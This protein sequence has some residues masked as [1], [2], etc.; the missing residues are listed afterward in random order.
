MRDQLYH[1]AE[2]AQFYDLDTGWSDDLAYCAKMAQSARSVLDLGCGTGKFLVTIADKRLVGVDPAVAMLDIARQKPSRAPVTWVQGDARNLQLG[3]T[4]DLIV[5]TG[6]A[7]QTLLTDD[8]QRAACQTIAAHLAPD[9]IFIFDSREPSVEE[10]RG[11]TPA[12]SERTIGHPA[13]GVIRAWNDVAFDAVTGIATYWTYY[14]ARDGQ[15]W[16]AISCIRF[17]SKDAINAR[18]TEAGMRVNR[19]LGDWKGGPIGP[20]QPEIIAIGG[21][22]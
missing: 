22:A 5:M 9:G 20:S 10:W 14:E 18:I 6:H 7:Y 2:L 15:T 11:W 1:D 3:Q 13:L 16:S 12:A 8:D 4:F 21:L 19:W 17:A